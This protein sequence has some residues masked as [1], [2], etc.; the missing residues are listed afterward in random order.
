MDKIVNNVIS[1][2]ST[3]IPQVNK[4]RDEKGYSKI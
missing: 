2:Y 4:I 3:G 1:L